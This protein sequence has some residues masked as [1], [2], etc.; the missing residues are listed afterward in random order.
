MKEL[1]AAAGLAAACAKRRI[2]PH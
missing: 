1:M 2:R